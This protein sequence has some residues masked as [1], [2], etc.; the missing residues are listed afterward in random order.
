[1][2][3]RF[4]KWNLSFGLERFMSGIRHDHLHELTLRSEPH[5]TALSTNLVQSSWFPD[6]GIASFSS[7]SNLAAYRDGLSRRSPSSPVDGMHSSSSRR[8]GSRLQ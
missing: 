3:M 6:T 5:N 1:M 7:D 2:E 4:V 8:V